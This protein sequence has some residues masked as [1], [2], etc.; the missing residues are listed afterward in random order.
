MV[1]AEQ[2]QHRRMQVMDTGWFLD[3]F[4]TKIVGR[5][6]GGT[7]PDTTSRQPDTE[8]IMIMIAAKLRFPVSAKFDRWRPTEFAATDD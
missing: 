7:T 3:R 6:I 8:S 1:K 4:E 2:V 5:S